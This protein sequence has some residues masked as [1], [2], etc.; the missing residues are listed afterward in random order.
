MTMSLKPLQVSHVRV[1][2]LEAGVR[3]Q[4]QLCGSPVFTEN[5]ILFHDAIRGPG[6]STCEA[7]HQ[8]IEAFLK[9]KPF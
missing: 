6:W 5:D 3:T 2:G 9:T 1:V 8:K 4:R 7:C